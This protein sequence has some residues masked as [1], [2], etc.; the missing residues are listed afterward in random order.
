TLLH[1]VAPV[2][3]AVGGLVAGAPWLML[4]FGESYAADGTTIL[5]VLAVSCLPWAVT[6]VFIAHE[7]A[8]GRTRSVAVVQVATLLVF[9]ASTSAMLDSQGAIAVAF[10]W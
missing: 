8:A 6:T 10:G 7:R 2:A 4:L 1:A 9:V 5:R 3:L